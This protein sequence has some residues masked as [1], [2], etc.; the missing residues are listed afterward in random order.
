LSGGRF[1]FGLGVGGLPEVKRLT[2]ERPK[3]PVKV[4]ERAVL[5]LKEKLGFEVY[6]GVRGPR[7]LGLAGRVADGVILSGPKGYIEKAIEI[8]DD[9]SNGRDVRKVLWN[10]FYL[11][12]DPKLVSKVTSVMLE[13]MPGFALQYMEKGKAEEELCIYG[14][15]ERILE[16]IGVYEKMGVDEFV[17]GPPYGRDP[18]KVIVEL[19]D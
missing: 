1:T 4:L 3:K 2:E 12:E 11:G 6:L 9:S 7:M 18:L 13:S 19:G 10:A 16:E 5:S 14:S 8:V 17:V 15:K